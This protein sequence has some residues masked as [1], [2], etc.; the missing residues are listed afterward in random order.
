MKIQI[1]T[2]QKVI[3][4]ESS[5]NLGEF[6]IA[7]QQMLPNDLWKDFKIETNTHIVW[8]N[9]IIWRDIYVQPRI[10]PLV[11]PWI[12]QPIQPSPY[13]ATPWITCGNDI[14][15]QLQSGSYN[16]EF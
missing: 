1:D 4:L 15:Y 9:P 2:T 12:T 3:K 8:L 13:P 11:V 14:P 16:V 7:I 10:Q 5:E 6:F